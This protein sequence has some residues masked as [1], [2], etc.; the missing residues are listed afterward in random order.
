VL[1]RVAAI[2]VQQ[3]G[4][5]PVAQLHARRRAARRPMEPRREWA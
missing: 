1:T 2:G 3:P 4:L 5:T